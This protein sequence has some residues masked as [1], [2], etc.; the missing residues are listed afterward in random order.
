MKKILLFLFLI[1]I[2]ILGVYIL[3]TQK[4]LSNYIKT[5]VNT[6]TTTT[7]IVES[8]DSILILDKTIYED[9][10]N[11]TIDVHYPTTENKIIDDSIFADIEKQ[12][13]DFKSA[14]IKPS[15]NSAKTTLII[16]YQTILNQED[17]LSIKFSSESYTGGAHPSHLI[18]TKNFVVSKSKEIPFEEVIVDEIML[19]SVSEYAIKNLTSQKQDYEFFMEGFNPIKKNYQTFALNDKGIIFYFNEYQIAP[20]YAGNFELFMPYSEIDLSGLETIEEI[21]ID[22]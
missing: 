7:T 3:N 22:E 14:V 18:W 11:Y 2:I 4:Q 16:N 20:Y 17:I 10:N 8:S 13:S 1:I 6:P 19:K 15:P 21:E 9:K 12:V 5:K